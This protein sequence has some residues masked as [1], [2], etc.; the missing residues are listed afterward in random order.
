MPVADLAFGV[1]KW[2]DYPNST[3]TG[4]DTVNH[5][6]S[7][8]DLPPNCIFQQANILGELPFKNA[9]FDYVFQRFLFTSFSP[10]EWGLAIKELVR[11]LKPGGWI[12]SIEGD[13]HMEGHRRIP[14]Y[15]KQVKYILI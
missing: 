6:P 5:F 4:I 9:M 1:S 8:S 12:E 13:G 7:S 3:F 2:R 11:V 15:T 14:D 10:T